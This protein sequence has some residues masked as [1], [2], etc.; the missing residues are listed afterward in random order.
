MIS[1]G[2]VIFGFVCFWVLVHSGTNSRLGNNMDEVA[3]FA[4]LS[5]CLIA[6]VLAVAG[7]RWDRRKSPGFVALLASL[8]GAFLIYALGG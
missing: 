6:I 4:V 3:K 5:P 8:A 2:C 1:F 7:L